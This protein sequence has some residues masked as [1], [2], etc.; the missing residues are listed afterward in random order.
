[1]P[2]LTTAPI[3]IWASIFI[4]LLVMFWFINPGSKLNQILAWLAYTFANI[5]FFLAVNWTAVNYYMRILPL[6]LSLAL[7]IRWLKPLRNSPWLPERTVTS[8]GLTIL[9]LALIGSVGYVDY[10]VNQST[11]LK[12]INQVPLLSMFPVRTGLYTVINGGNGLYG[13]AMNAYSTNWLGQSVEGNDEMD[14]AVDIIEIRTSG[15]AAKRIL[16]KDFRDYEIFN[17]LV[18]SPCVGEVIS[19]EDGHP[20]VSPLSPGAGAGNQI[21]IRCADFL[22]TLSNLRNGSIDVTVGEQIDLR[23]QVAQVGSSADQTVPHLHMHVTTLDGEPVPILFEAGY[24][25]KFVARNY[26]YVR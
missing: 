1:M 6:A 5:Y 20:E 17:E 9:L 14:F 16:S 18:Y 4:P 2:W 13:W 23:R 7:L 12:N 26:I 15:A 10:R 8:L 25:F 11:S 21:M 3:L 22:I 24:S 19:V